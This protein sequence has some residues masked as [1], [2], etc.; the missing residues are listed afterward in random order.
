MFLLVPAYPGS[1]G[2]RAVKRLL[3]LLADNWAVTLMPEINDSVYQVN[4]TIIRNI[5]NHHYHLPNN[6][7]R[8]NNF[9]DWMP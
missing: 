5:R 7:T 1:P 4:V 2:R 8:G 6:W 3:L 9:Y